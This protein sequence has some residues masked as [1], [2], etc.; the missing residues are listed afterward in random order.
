MITNC[1]RWG[2][3]LICSWPPKKVVGQYFILYCRLLVDESLVA[4][5]KRLY[6]GCTNFWPHWRPRRLLVSRTGDQNFRFY[7]LS[8]STGR[9]RHARFRLVNFKRQIMFMRYVFMTFPFWAWATPLQ[10]QTMDLSP[11]LN[12]TSLDL[13]FPPNATVQNLDASSGRGLDIRCDGATY[14]FNPSLSD[15]EIARSFIEPIQEQ[16]VFGER[17]TGLPESTFP[18]P[19]MMMGGTLEEIGEGSI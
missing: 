12:L 16:F 11:A 6:G 1:M 18:L 17:H 5:S 8:S 19:Y 14:G 10:G 7:L 2:M 4:N 13:L 9:S 3:T 15:C